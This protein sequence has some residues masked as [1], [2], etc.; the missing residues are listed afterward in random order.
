M[1]VT[2]VNPEPSREA[3]LQQAVK[4]LFVV[5]MYQFPRTVRGNFEHNSELQ[6]L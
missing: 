6:P 2:L 3:G 5:A 1:F 4:A